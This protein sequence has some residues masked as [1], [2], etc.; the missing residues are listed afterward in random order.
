[1]SSST[2]TR[3]VPPPTAFQFESRE[4]Q[5]HAVRLGMWL[6]LA[7][8]LLLFAGL[9][10]LY[11][12]YRAQFREEF[13]AAA[14]VNDRLLG[15]INTVVLITSSFTV[16]MAIHA[17]RTAR[18]RLAVWLLGATLALGATFMVIKGL[19]YGHHMHQGIYPG[20]Y[21]HFA[22]MPTAAGRLFFTLYYFMT[23]LHASHVIGGMVFLGVLLVKVRR[24]RYSPVGYLPLELGGLYWHLVDVIWIF[25]WPLLYLTR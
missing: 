11:A 17:V 18:N 14:K 15:T 5:D 4:K 10:A 21:Y 25:L 22:E 6:F 19:E 7:S 23:G 24:G 13:I 16:A 3:A 1:M 20:S 12:A 9:F 2:S 8:E